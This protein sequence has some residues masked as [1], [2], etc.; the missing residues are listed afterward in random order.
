MKEGENMANQKKKTKFSVAE[1]N[2]IFCNFK[3]TRNAAD[4]KFSDELNGAR[5][6]L[7]YIKKQME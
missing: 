5:E 2:E 1:L 6:F 4:D 3:K 7:A